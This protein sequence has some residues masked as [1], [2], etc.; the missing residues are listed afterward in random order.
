MRG[1]GSLEGGTGELVGAGEE[2]KEDEE[3]FLQGGL[4]GVLE[5]LEEVAEGGKDVASGGERRA[6]VD[7]GGEVG[8]DDAEGGGL[9]ASVGE[10]GDGGGMG[11]SRA[12]GGRA[13]AADAEGVGVAAGEGVVEVPG[14]EGLV[15][16]RG[17]VNRGGGR[18]GGLRV[19]A[20][21]A[22]FWVSELGFGDLR[23][24]EIGR[25]HV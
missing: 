24:A 18:Q 9:G 12:D 6:E 23:S 19:A 13:A 15:H 10:V 14:V 20:R 8:V 5:A 17:A 16:H 21:R 1:P 11:G 3:V 22:A 25:A 7:G 2:A 4:D